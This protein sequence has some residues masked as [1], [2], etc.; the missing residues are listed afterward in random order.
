MS[1]IQFH[2]EVEQF[3]HAANKNNLRMLMVGGIAVN[4]YGYKRQNKTS[5]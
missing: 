3:I 4:Y 5:P 2:K 1:D